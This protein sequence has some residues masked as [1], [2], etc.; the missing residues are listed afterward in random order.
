MATLADFHLAP[1]PLKSRRIWPWKGAEEQNKV[2]TIDILT[3]H[4]LVVRRE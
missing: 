4:N 1:I 2:E 3:E